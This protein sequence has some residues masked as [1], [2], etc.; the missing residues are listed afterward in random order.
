[1]PVIKKKREPLFVSEM[2]LYAQVF[3]LPGEGFFL[4]RKKRILKT[5]DAVRENTTTVKE[6]IISGIFF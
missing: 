6:A 5:S 3:P 1:M 2:A 4:I